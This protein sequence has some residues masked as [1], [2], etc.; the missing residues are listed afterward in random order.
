MD[1]AGAN[2]QRPSEAESEEQSEEEGRLAPDY[3]EEEVADKVDNVVP[4]FAYHAAPVVGLGGSAGSLAALKTFFE[5]MPHDTGLSFVVVTH[6]SP[7]HESLMA[8][9]LQTCT[10][11]KVTQVSE[12]AAI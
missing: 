5:R 10:S 8:E 6:L 2:N 1:T 11:M 4:T 12:R 7:D 3:A 9:I